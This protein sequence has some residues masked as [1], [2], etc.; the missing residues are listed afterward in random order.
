MKKLTTTHRTSAALA[1]LGIAC[2]SI[3]AC[4]SDE[5]AS[6]TETSSDT[7]EV[8]A[9]DTTAATEPAATEPAATDTAPTD[10]TDDGLAYISDLDPA[11][12]EPALTF[13]EAYGNLDEPDGVDQLMALVSDDIVIEDML[14]GE[15]YSGREDVRAWVAGLNETFGIDGAVCPGDAVQGASWTAGPYELWVADTVLSQGIAA[16][17]VNDQGLVERQV[18]FYTPSPDGTTQPNVDQGSGVLSIGMQYCNAWGDEFSEGHEAPDPDKIVS[19]MSAEP[20]IHGTRTMTGADQ[21]RTFA[22]NAVWD[23]NECSVEVQAVQWE[24]VANRFF[25]DDTGTVW[26][27]VNVIELDANESVADHWTYLEVVS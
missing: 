19:L 17:R 21:I 23:R 6:T 16:V 5:G 2:A 1:V 25:D 15:T 20:T 26:E 9:D 27:G 4:G 10:L 13:C 3:A 24:A 22:E 11:I 12:T 14:L 8:V 18:N 7:T